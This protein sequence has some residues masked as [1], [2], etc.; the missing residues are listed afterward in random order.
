MSERH[1]LINSHKSLDSTSDN[2]SSAPYYGTKLQDYNE[3]EFQA[4][5]EHRERLDKILLDFGLGKFQYSLFL[6]CGFGWLTENVS[7]EKIEKSFFFIN[8]IF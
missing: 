7:F 1:Q 8:I 2:A 6:L 3:S 5:L 4:T